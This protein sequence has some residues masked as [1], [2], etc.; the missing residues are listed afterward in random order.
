M[1]ANTDY[2]LELSSSTLNLPP[3][4]AKDLYQTHYGSVI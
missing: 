2:I 4:Q 3:T 1:S